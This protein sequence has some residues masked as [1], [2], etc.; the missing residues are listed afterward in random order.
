[1]KRSIYIFFMIWVGVSDATTAQELLKPESA[2]DSSPVIRL[3]IDTS[4][5]RELAI[6]HNLGFQIDPK[7]RKYDP[8]DAQRTWDKVEIKRAADQPGWYVLT[9]SNAQ[10]KVAYRARP[11]FEGKD[12]E[13]ALIT[14]EQRAAAYRQKLVEKRQAQ[15][16]LY[17]QFILDAAALGKIG[18]IDERRLQYDSLV[19][20]T[21][22]RLDKLQ[23]F[24][25]DP[26]NP[27]RDIQAPGTSR[28]FLPSVSYKLVPVSA[29][30]RDSAGQ[31]L[32]L[33]NVDVLFRGFQMLGFDDG[34][35]I[36]VAANGDNMIFG[37]WHGK[38]YMLSFDDYRQLHVTEG[39]RT[40]T[41]PMQFADS[42]YQDLR[43]YDLRNLIERFRPNR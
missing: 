40:L 26:S 19:T 35:H 24:D 21:G 13:Q 16:K 2:N 37:V 11:V 10:R 38:L 23:L 29:S 18:N 27:V 25:I 22:K 4:Q 31:A 7:G 6:Y 42:V 3:D 33:T 15:E 30:Y 32:E 43:Y 36:R 41:F 20:V 39:T 12:Y 5:F 8:Q 14:Y 17:K 34:R 28:G 1:M 9:F